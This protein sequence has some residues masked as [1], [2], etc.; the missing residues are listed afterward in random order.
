MTTFRGLNL[1]TLKIL[2]PCLSA[3]LVPCLSATPALAA[4]A[5]RW[6]IVSFTSPTN[7]APNTPTN[8]VQ[9]LTVDATGG[10]FTV[11]FPV[12][13][14]VCYSP[15]TTA[16]LPFDATAVEVQ[17]ALEALE[18]IGG[19]NVTVTGGS[20]GSAPYVVT[21]IG[22]SVGARPLPVM[23]AD[24]SLL[25]GG[26]ATATLSE[27]T[28]GAPAPY[29]LVKA[30]NVGGAAT[31]GSTV[32]ID[33]A[34]PAALS[35][36]TISGYD[37]YAV[38]FT[39]SSLGSA[40]CTTVPG[41]SCSYSGVIDP[42]DTLVMRVN[43]ET[44]AT[45]LMPEELNMAQ[46]SGGGA[47][48]VSISTPI[49][50]GAVPAVFGPA[51]GSVSATL[52]TSQAGAHANVTTAF[53]LNSEMPSVAT[54]DLRDVHFDLPPGLVG[55]T[56]GMP[57]C[58]MA[59]ILKAISE[60]STCPSDTVVG[61]AILT[62]ATER[63]VAREI[64][65]VTPVYNIAP[66]PGEPAAFALN[67]LFLPVRLDTSVLSDGNFAVRVSSSGLTEAA[68]TLGASITIWGVPADHSGPGNDRSYYTVLTGSPPFGGATGQ[69]R[70]PLLS[71]PQ[72]CSTPLSAELTVDSW[73]NP[74]HFVSS[75]VV[76]MGTLTGCDQLSLESS[77]SMLP[78][79]LE[80]G[81]PAGYSFDLNVPQR[82]E[83]DG[84]ATPNVKDVKLTLPAGVVVNPSAAWGLKACSDA[85]FFGPN[86]G[87]QEP[88]TLSECPREAQVGK[89]R[90][91]SPALEEALEGQVYL[92]EPECNP[93]TPADA[94]DGKMIRLFLQVV[95]EGEGGVIVKLAGR[96]SIDQQ[97]GQ[98]TTTFENNPQLPFNSLKLELGGGPRAV[99]ANPRTCGPVTSNL[100][101]TPWSSP[102]TSDS[103]PR[104]SFE[105]N[106]GCFGAQFSP[107]FVGGVTSIQAG[108]YSPFTLSFGRSDH[109]QFLAGIS[110]Q[111]PPGLLG[112]LSGVELCKEPQASTGNC[113]PNSLIGHVQALTG[114][115]ADPFL[116]SGG[117]VFITEGYG[118]A[119]YGLSIVVP[120]VAGP[121]TLA[122]TT[123]QGTVVVR[124]KILVDPHTAALTV[125]SDPLP[126]MLDG[127]PLQLKAVNVTI[128]RPEFTFNPTNCNKTSI[129]GTLTSAE[130]L[131]A[132]VSTSFQVTNCATLAFKPKF[133]VS[134]S[135]KTSR[136]NGAS[137]D[138][139]LSYPNTPQGT[140]ANIAKVKVELPRALPSRL[141]T[142]QKACIAAQF[143]SNPAGC[144]TASIVGHAKAI[145]PLIPVP[146]E[147]PAYFVSHGGEAFPSLIVVLQ[148]Y[149]LK[150]E[151]VGSTFI[152]KS[153][154]T[155]STFK[156]I[157][158]APVGT[159][160]LTLP[161]GPYSALA[162]NTNL[163]KRKLA[164][165]TE[166]V[167]QNGAVLKQ[168]TKIAVT[169]CPKHKAKRARRKGRGGG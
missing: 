169:D 141:P 32:T 121:Y 66:A 158:D 165:G 43:L 161:Q 1:R 146:L 9:Q 147:G 94:Q 72:Q 120:A 119:P 62:F 116:V 104:Y 133:A 137:L 27:T 28:R 5:P 164:M 103:T 34:L 31:D 67:A 55:N 38:G 35:A 58:S 144:P 70:V 49:T 131:S 114:P 155:S 139:K 2:V 96:G 71:N 126:T 145:T 19:S 76:P 136:R 8:E 154:I 41:I 156:T 110:T 68:V 82:N 93:C 166:F 63:T 20:G 23:S 98:I 157:P 122:G 3:C 143:E 86:R 6:N 128:D 18:C 25:T 109:D 14:G 61:M 46:V 22:G 47:A 79:T 37:A 142:L 65:V 50:I 51:P 60:P 140:E 40:T 159:F 80:A 29:M 160:E 84:L 152:G 153:G 115:G 91:K 100:D 106:Q 138:V 15:G 105:I 149:G 75:G 56:V 36:T 129:N 54:A 102:F 10:T 125:T 21:F 167:A 108:A 148:G 162:A 52:S 16:P 113:G 124:A 151:L 17:A 117:H 12:T 77:F 95:S 4:E 90:V 81:A 89:V 130:G 107:S 33:D 11:T 73:S 132:N 48:Q 39:S 123:G 101:L 112:K 74:G 45:S 42:G 57:T 78:D 83:P 44:A 85:Q 13:Q 24:S 127:I 64:T 97:T 135:S 134:T 168:K 88:A 111:M 99:L 92:A 59:Q 7:L 30:T 53:A 26:V 118:G 87:R 69:T 150:L 163:C